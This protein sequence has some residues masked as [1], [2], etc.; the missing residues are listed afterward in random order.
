M[1]KSMR[2]KF[3]ER[4]GFQNPRD[5]F[6]INSIDNALRNRIWNQIQAF[7]IDRIPLDAVYRTYI[8]SSRDID[9]FKKTYD[10]F[11]KSNETISKRIYTLKDDIK[12]IYF[13][14]NWYEIY[15]F[16][17]FISEI[18]HDANI[19]ILFRKK[20]NEV[21][22]SEMS[23]YRFINNYIARII[24]EAE[25]KSIEDA[26]SSEYT[27][28]KQ[29]LSKALE[30]L[31]DRENPDYINSIKESIS[32]LESLGKTFACNNGSP[33]PSCLNQLSKLD[34]DSHLKTGF[35]KLYNWTST[36]GGIRHGN[37]GETMK[38]S[39]A[40]AK[41]MLVSCSAFINY[42]ID[43]SHEQTS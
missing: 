20:I 13:K 23:A 34:I 38:I 43:K 8:T 30:H 19:N 16:I 1:D 10:E 28:V 12:R 3:S 41:F 18:Y 14:F 37:S 24:E 33:L 2:Q 42:L 21:L 27:N 35:I 32:A 5:T 31:S 39:F 25:I 29:H 22:E 6:Q 40:E 11:F 4:C 26:L 17:E 36:A 7:Y 9:F 15:D